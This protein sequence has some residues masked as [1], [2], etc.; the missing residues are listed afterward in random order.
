V[1]VEVTA[2]ADVVRARIPWHR[3]DADFRTKDVLVYD[4]SA[5]AKINNAF[6]CNLTSDGPLK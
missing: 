1:N 5:G 3:H 2:P 6:A 4:I